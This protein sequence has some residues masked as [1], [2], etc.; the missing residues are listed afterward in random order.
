M[1]KFVIDCNIVASNVAGN[2]S[3]S[4]PKPC[5]QSIYSPV[6]SY[7]KLSTLKLGNTQPLLDQYYPALEVRQRLEPEIFTSD[8]TMYQR[9][10]THSTEL[11]SFIE[12]YTSGSQSML[13]R[14][15]DC[16]TAILT[17]ALEQDINLQFV[18]M[19]SYSNAMQKVFGQSLEV[20]KNNAED[21]YTKLDQL[22]VATKMYLPG[23]LGNTTIRT[24][25]QDASVI[26]NIQYVLT[27]TLLNL[28]SFPENLTL[29]YDIS[30]EHFPQTFY[31]D[32]ILCLNSIV[33]YILN[34]FQLLSDLTS[35][36][37]PGVDYSNVIQNS[38]NLLKT[39]GNVLVFCNINIILLFCMVSM[40]IILFP[41]YHSLSLFPFLFLYSC[42]IP[43]PFFFYFCFSYEFSFCLY[44]YFHFSLPFSFRLS[45]PFSFPFSI[46]FTTYSLY[47]FFYFSLFF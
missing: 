24:L 2:S 31:R 36:E 8:I 44:F 1:C 43:F 10:L 18:N 4:C 39:E 15:W 16:G 35:Y 20:H 6:L 37:R 40:L 7:A 34:I 5:H 9:L 45:F 29:T 33:K 21:L 17:E 19:K 13:S 38:L 12:E 32:E 42:I 25:I 23:E 41:T 26:S 3:C 47:I 11:T 46:S 14:I 30:P 28:M 22:I 27:R